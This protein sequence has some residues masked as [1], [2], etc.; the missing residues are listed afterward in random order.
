LFG[1]DPRGFLPCRGLSRGL[2]ALALQTRGVDASGFLTSSLLPLCLQLCRRQSR[3]LLAL[4]LQSRRLDASGFLTF[5]LQS[6]GR[7]PFG[8]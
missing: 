1:R 7:L 5:S 8:V 4:G 2:L 6:S 3:G